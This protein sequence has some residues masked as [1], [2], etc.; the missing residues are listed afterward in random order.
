MNTSDILINMNNVTFDDMVCQD[1]ILTDADKSHYQEKGYIIPYTKDEFEKE[2]EVNSSCVFYTPSLSLFS[3]YINFESMAVCS[4]HLEMTELE[5]MDN[6]KRQIP[7]AVARSEEEVKQHSFLN[8]ILVLPDAMRFDYLKQ[9][10]QKYPSYDGIYSLF[11]SVYTDSDYGFAAMGNETAR[12]LLRQK[13]SKDVNETKQRISG[14]PDRVKV[15]R[16]GNSKSV[17]YNS[18]YSWTRDINVAYF[19]AARRGDGPGYV[20][21]GYVDK[22]N[23]IE[24]LPDDRGESEIIADPQNVTVDKVTRLEGID[25]LKSV[26]PLISPIFNEYCEKLEWLDFADATNEHGLSHE[27]RVLFLTLAIAHRLHL[28]IEDMHI[29]A[30]AS[31]FHDSQRTNDDVDENHGYDAKEYYTQT[32]DEP[33]AIVEFL[34]EFHCLP[35]SKGR[36]EI[37]QNPKLSECKNRVQMLYDVFKDADA[38][39]RTRFGDLMREPDIK[40]LRLDTSKELVLAARILCSQL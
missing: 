33:D 6:F 13:T 40:Q 35:D 14:L 15:Y 19:F 16:G 18:A 25:Y 30:T 23:I 37:K 2:F 39:D 38:L 20:A 8:S 4:L 27:R 3:V 26:E 7:V 22:R 10:L 31:I 28:P 12:T 9:L 32:E 11:M 21:E 24:Y 17:P 1:S 34:C 36:A 5:G 29:L